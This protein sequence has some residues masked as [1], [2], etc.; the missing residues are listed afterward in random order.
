MKVGVR[1]LCI[2]Q[3][4]R[5]KASSVW[6]SAFLTIIH[7]WHLRTCGKHKRRYYS[8]LESAKQGCEFWNALSKV[9]KPDL[10]LKFPPWSGTLI[11]VHHDNNE[12][13]FKIPARLPAKKSP[14]V[15]TSLFCPQISSGLNSLAIDG[16]LIGGRSNC[17]WDGE[18]NTIVTLLGC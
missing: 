16:V 3:E 7:P 10:S 11:L 2:M 13:R 12:L 14:R 9:C 18:R 4:S 8:Y 17:L 6:Y 15:Y 5:C 1:T